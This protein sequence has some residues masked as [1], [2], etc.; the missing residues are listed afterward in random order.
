MSGY[1]KAKRRLDEVSGVSGWRLHD[2][3]RTAA[4]GMIRLGVA[5]QVLS[6]ILNHGPERFERATDIYNRHGYDDEKRAALDAW[7]EHVGEIESSTSPTLP[8]QVDDKWLA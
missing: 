5:S 6:R 2:L 7:A 4:T 8:D 1:S 3:R